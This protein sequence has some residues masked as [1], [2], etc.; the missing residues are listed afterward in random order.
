[1]SGNCLLVNVWI[2]IS[3][4]FDRM[5]LPT[6]WITIRSCPKL[7]GTV[8]WT[9]RTIRHQTF[10]MLVILINL[11]WKLRVS[12]AWVTCNFFVWV[13]NY[14]MFFWTLLINSNLLIACRF[15]NLV[16]SFRALSNAL[17]NLRLKW[18]CITWNLITIS[19]LVS[20]RINWR[21]A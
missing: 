1:M 16:F 20:P 10:S 21:S 7:A 15:Y 4:C 8:S 9:P 17:G 13:N 2:Y 14:W 19:I 11:K 12:C 6:I 3:Y 18:D 5:R